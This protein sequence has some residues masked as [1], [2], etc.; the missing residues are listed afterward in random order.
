MWVGY[1]FGAPVS[2][3]PIPHRPPATASPGRVARELTE[4]EVSENRASAAHYARMS[5]MY[6][7]LDG[8]PPTPPD[9]DASA[10]PFYVDER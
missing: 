7:G 8:G 6:L 1:G 3:G 10:N 4:A 9:E 2:E 5:R